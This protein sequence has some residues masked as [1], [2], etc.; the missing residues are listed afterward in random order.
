MNAFYAGNGFEVLDRND[1][2]HVRFENMW[3]VADE[4]L[5]DLPS[6]IFPSCTRRASHFS[7]S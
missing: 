5:F 1:I 6:V 3:G 2:E 7:R 4:D